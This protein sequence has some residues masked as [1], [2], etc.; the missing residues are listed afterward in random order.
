MIRFINIDNN[1]VYNGDKPYV[2]WFEGQQSVDL[3]YTQRLCVLTDQKS[4]T[5]SIPNT[6]DVDAL[7]TN[8]TSYTTSATDVI[9]KITTYVH[10]KDISDHI[11]DINRRV[12]IKTD[13]YQNLM[14]DCRKIVFELEEVLQSM[15]DV[16]KNTEDK[17]AAA[18]IY[19]DWKSAQSLLAITKSKLD[20]VHN[21]LYSGIF[22][23][24]DVAKFNRQEEID[25]I[26]YQDIQWMKC[27][28][29]TLTGVSYHDYYVYMLYFL[30]SSDTAMEAR[31]SFFINDE[32]FTIGADFYE[33]R[34]ELKINLG[35]NGVD[36][37]ESVQ[38]AIY[39]SNVHEEA[40]D[41]ILMNRKYKELLMDYMD[42]LG[43]KGNYSSLINSLNWFEYGDLLKLKEFWKH[44]EWEKVIYSDQELQQVLTDKA[45]SMLVNFA[46]TTYIGIY[47]AMQTEKKQVYS[48]GTTDGHYA[49]DTDYLTNDTVINGYTLKSATLNEELPVDQEGP[50]V[51]L[52]HFRNGVSEIQN[53][54][55]SPMQEEIQDGA[56][57][58]RSSAKYKD[59]DRFFGEGVPLLLQAAYKWSRTDMAIKMA[60]LGNF[61][62][63]YFMPIHLDLIHSTIEDIIYTNSIKVIPIGKIDRED[64]IQGLGSVVC[65]VKDGDVYT[66]GDVEVQAAYETLFSERFVKPVIPHTEQGALWREHPEYWDAD[67]SDIP[68]IFGTDYWKIKFQERDLYVLWQSGDNSVWVACPTAAGLNCSLPTDCY[69]ADAATMTIY[70][71]NIPDTY[72][73]DE[74]CYEFILYYD[75][76][77]ILV[78]SHVK[79][80]PV[81]YDW[82][83]LY[84]D[85]HP[86][87]VTDMVDKIQPKDSTHNTGELIGSDDP[88]DPDLRNFM[89]NN[90]NGSG[91][92]IP[93]DISIPC[94]TDDVLKRVC[95]HM[96]P[97]DVWESR[98][99]YP[100]LEEKEGFIRVVF[101]MLLTREQ[102]YDIRFEFDL[103]CGEH[104]TKRV[105]LDVVDNRRST[106]KVYKIKPIKGFLNNLTTYKANDYMFTHTRSLLHGDDLNDYQATYSQFIP[107]VSENG[108]QMSHMIVIKNVWT[109][110]SGEDKYIYKSFQDLLYG[111][112]TY[113]AGESVQTTAQDASVIQLLTRYYDVY[114]RYFLKDDG[115][116]SVESDYIRYFIL[117][118]NTFDKDILDK[119]KQ[120]LID[121]KIGLRYGGTYNCCKNVPATLIDNEKSKFQLVLRSDD[122]YVP[123]YHQLE[124]LEGDSLDDY[125][126]TDETLCVIPDIK[127]LSNITDYEWTFHNASTGEDILMPSIK[128]PNI[129]PTTYQTLPAGFYDIRFRY[130]IGRNLTQEVSLDSAFF[131]KP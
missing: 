78:N 15:Y 60:L 105:L 43:T 69:K 125:T 39:P 19:E 75:M 71:K 116:T 36:L 30:A 129:A 102:Q 107:R 111:G 35:N 52:R 96:N 33:E 48:D 47:C 42:I 88:R 46:K 106:L 12:S 37:P 76:S 81:V 20:D 95:I 74:G 91:V 120:V 72:K 127:Y 6:I 82:S 104:Y 16:Y 8:I 53:Y 87:G 66:L 94:H 68:C 123:H 89:I 4:I 54:P 79:L 112:T 130:R 3:L 90:Y 17:A 70:T 73:T 31:Q 49:Y 23:L 86:F 50:D 98:T 110:E 13:E 5:A 41:D 51:M 119:C 22:T 84:D 109:D 99:F 65:N 38:R 117:V 34:E 85:F 1:R 126:I 18:L 24:L 2:H 56:N 77:G 10:T 7:Y 92:V 59:D 28:S 27:N 100:M 26:T 40:K 62:S 67:W 64:Y 11:D 83:T 121:S 80:M 14:D 93:V 29:I 108:I 122:V 45:K 115:G 44:K 131:Q 97:D 21:T 103:T 9:S 63:T 113:G 124:E 128:E 58:I 32:E 114:Y 25:E 57:F 118:S 55:V 101:N 61:Y